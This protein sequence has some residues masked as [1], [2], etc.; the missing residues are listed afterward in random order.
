MGWN[1]MR[2]QIFANQ[3]KLGVIPATAQLTPWPDDLE[4]WDALSADEKKLFARQA[5]VFAGY[6]AYTDHEIGRVIQAVEDMGKLDNTLI[7]Y[8]CG[9]NGTSP[10]GTTVGTF[11]QYTAYN[12]ILDVPIADQLK[13]YDA[14]GFRHDLST[15]GGRMVLGVRYS[16]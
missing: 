13:A 15:H 14:W 12:G 10:E 4:K 6:T 5:E 11:N 9:D 1:E 7:I 2:E 8:M 16:F 3:K